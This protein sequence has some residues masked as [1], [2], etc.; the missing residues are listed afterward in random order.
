[1]FCRSLVARHTELWCLGF[2]KSP[3]EFQLVVSLMVARYSNMK[4]IKAAYQA[5]F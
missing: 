1:M 3:R 5:I 4:V 2:L